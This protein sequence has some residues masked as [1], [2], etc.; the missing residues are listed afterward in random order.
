MDSK[1]I[2]ILPTIYTLEALTHSNNK[3]IVSLCPDCLSR[4]KSNK[5]YKDIHQFPNIT[6]N[7]ICVSCGA[8]TLTAVIS[9]FNIS[10]YNI[11]KNTQEGV[12]TYRESSETTI[13]FKIEPVYLNILKGKLK[14]GKV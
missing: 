12:F 2:K 14:N 13:Q 9:C 6:Q 3:K 8:M 4:F 5:V 11:C 7:R 10:I 1:I